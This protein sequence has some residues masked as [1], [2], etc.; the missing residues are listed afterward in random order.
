MFRA[1]EIQ[2]TI[3]GL[4][5]YFRTT[6]MCVFLKLFLVRIEITQLFQIYSVFKKLINYI[7]LI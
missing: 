7:I 3:K 1:C 5:T 4:P 6:K 2:Y